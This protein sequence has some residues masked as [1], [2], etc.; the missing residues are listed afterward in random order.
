MAD[1]IAGPFATSILGDFGAE[2][3]RI[4]LPGQVANTR[5][6]HGLDAA[7]PER[8]P[9][10]ATF[11]HGKKS[12]TLD[13]RKEEGKSL[14]LDLVAR[15]HVL[16]EAFRPGTLESW[17]LDWEVLEGA[18]PALILLRIS[19]YGQTGPWSGRPG[20]DR[21]AQAFAGTTSI[22]G[23]PDQP[24][25]RPGIG[26]ADY[27]AGLWGVTG[28]LLSLLHMK[29]TGHRRG[30]V[31]DQA[32]YSAVL[33]MLCE[34]PVT[35]RREG[36]V[37]ERYGNQ[38]RGVAPGGL[39]ETADRKWMQISGSGPVAW[40][41][42]TRSMRRRDLLTDERFATNP[43][44][45]QNVDA[46]MPIVAEWVRT[47]TAEELDALLL[48][49]G[50]PAVVVQNIEDLMT[51]SHVIEREDFV[52]IEDPILGTLPAYNVQPRLS[53]T[54][55]HVRGTGP[56]LGEHNYEIYRDLLGVSETDL[57]ALQLHGVI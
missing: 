45:D 5:V 16:V 18:N 29:N 44:R 53:R 19:G 38:V 40:A 56:R 35:Y 39:F 13:V 47:K 23:Y 31:I 9:F 21:V 20:F 52:D 1:W 25:V 57:A 4:D 15:S 22:T 17:G 10:F 6:L 46:L 24:P 33:P 55:G 36:K 50:V 12:V 37:V 32:L 42:L 7:D 51:H 11:A 26:V 54:P 28:V 27:S 2:V 30:Q 43:L 41:G 49:E 48:S 34:A 14:L 3:I 8:S